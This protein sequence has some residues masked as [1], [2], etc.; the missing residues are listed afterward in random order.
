MRKD[1]RKSLKEQEQERKE[2]EEWG[3]LRKQGMMKFILKHGVWF[4]GL[5]LGLAIVVMYDLSDDGWIISKTIIGSIIAGIVYGHILG[6]IYG[7]IVWRIRE[8]KWNRTIRL[9]DL[10]NI[11][12]YKSPK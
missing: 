7:V 6:T 5:P 12:G 4:Y 8:K 3:R 9:G 11:S 1:K 2:H 10:T